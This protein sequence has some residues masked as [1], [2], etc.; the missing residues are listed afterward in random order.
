MIDLYTAPTPNGFKASI[1][2]EELGLPYTVHKVDLRTGGQFAPEFLRISPNNKIPAI[3]DTEGDVA[4]FES[5]AVLLYLAEKAGKLL[6]ASGAA[7]ARVLSWMFFQAANTGPML[8]Q[9]HHFRTYHGETIQYAIDRYTSEGKRL[10]HVVDRQLSQSRYIAGDD[11]TIAD[12]MNLPW[13]RLSK[14]QGVDIAEYPNVVRWIAELEARPAV[15]KGLTIPP[16][17]TRPMD[18]AARE[19][20]FGKAQYERR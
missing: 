19:V 12:V 18:D 13:L 7:R 6:P 9:A 14:G 1:A 8:G 20:L 15:Q 10:Y 5:G 4:V 16:K 11:F 3:V 17:D 2:L